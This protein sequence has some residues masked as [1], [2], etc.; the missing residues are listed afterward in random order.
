MKNMGVMLDC[1]RNAVMSVDS[2]K[3]FIERIA[4]MGYNVLML[5]TEDTYEVDGEPYFGYMRGKYMKDELKEIVAYAKDF[6]IEVVPCIQTLAHLKQIFNWSV[7][8]DIKDVND[9]LLVGNEKTYALIENMF[10]TLR[11]CFSSERIHIGMDEAHMLGFGK[12]RSVNGI[13][14]QTDIFLEHLNKVCE[15]A[16]KYSFKPLIWSDMF[17]RMQFNGRYCVRE[18]EISEEIRNAVPQNVGLVFWDYYHDDNLVYEHMLNVHKSFNREVWFAGG[19]WKWV[20]FRAGNHRSLKNTLPALEECEKADVA[21]II[22]TAWGDDGNECSVNALLPS[23]FFASEYIKGNKDLEKIK[24]NFQ[25]LFDENFDDFLLLDL[26][27][28][29]EFNKRTDDASGSKTMLFSDPF[30][31]YLDSTVRGELAEDKYYAELAKKLKAAS[32]RS[33]NFS[34]IFDSYVALCEV[35][36]D[37]YSLGFITRKAYQERD[38]VQLKSLLHKYTSVINKLE[39]FIIVFRKMWFKENKPF[40]FEVQELRLGGLLLRLKS[41]KERLTSF[42]V[43][44]IECIEELEVNLLDFYG[45]EQVTP[46]VTDISLYTKIVS[47]N[48]L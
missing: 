23:L 13:R 47:P 11:E 32:L 24:K 18:G 25:A 14:P 22:M 33:K 1:S 45:Q 48:V 31:G 43:G 16:E 46:I 12:Y 19:A 3:R 35:L 4:K 28:P 15:I 2:L 20:G 36:S 17:F 39:T 10:K 5:Y 44:E 38:K 27:L 34:Y 26:I 41:C 42:V 21:N 37:K 40:G 8:Q 29:D 6:G 30:V 9:I 7:Y